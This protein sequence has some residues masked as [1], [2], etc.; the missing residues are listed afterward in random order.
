LITILE[1]IE[2]INKTD[3]SPVAHCRNNSKNVNHGKQTIIQSKSINQLNKPN[4][5]N[6][7]IFNDRIY[8][9]YNKKKD[10]N[11]LTNYY[12]NKKN[13]KLNYKI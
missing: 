12:I 5:K 2:L 9:K 4:S 3:Q 13:V 10:N 11:Y 8:S 6:E 7:R 1:L